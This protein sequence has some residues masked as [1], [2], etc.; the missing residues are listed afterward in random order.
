MEVVVDNT[1]VNTAVVVMVIL[2]GAVGIKDCTVAVVVNMLT[3]GFFGSV[4]GAEEI[5]YGCS[6]GMEDSRIGL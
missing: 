6:S 5:E 1:D 3:E 2:D 4:V